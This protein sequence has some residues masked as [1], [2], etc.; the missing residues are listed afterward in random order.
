MLWKDGIGGGVGA[1][2]TGV[3]VCTVLYVQYI[4]EQWRRAG[5]WIEAISCSWR[6]LRRIL[7]A[8]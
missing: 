2:M 8:V 5:S 3:R 1:K 7:A 6:V 4:H